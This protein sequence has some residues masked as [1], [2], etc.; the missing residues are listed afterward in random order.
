MNNKTFWIGLV[1]VF[2]LM[3]VIGFVVH[4]VLLK[5]TYAG[6]GDVFRSEAEMDGMLWM[7]MAASALTVFLFCFIFTK[8][9][10]G[11]G[12]AEGARYGLWMGL[13]LSIPVAVDQYVVYPLPSNVAVSWF[14]SGVVGFVIAGALLA[15]IYKPSGN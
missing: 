14:V 3:Q 12:I 1:A 11:K 7:M 6:L 10:E 2:V 9:Y 8:G 15:A 5:E 4:E 13:F